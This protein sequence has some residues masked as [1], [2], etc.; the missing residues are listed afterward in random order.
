MIYVVLRRRDCTVR[1]GLKGNR[2]VL[3]HILCGRDA[4]S[5]AQAAEDPPDLFALIKLVVEVVVVRPVEKACREDV[6]SLEP[7]LDRIH[8]FLYSR[9]GLLV[10]PRLGNHTHAKMENI[11]LITRHLFN[12]LLA[13]LRFKLIVRIEKRHIGTRSSGDS[14]MSGRKQVEVALV[15]KI[16]EARVALGQLLNDSPSA[17]RRGVIHANDFNVMKRLGQEASQA[18]LDVTFNVIRGNND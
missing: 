15:S 18:S 12:E 16:V 7:S 17:I 13:S 14:N 2:E 8:C 10:T 3:D 9:D 5:K 1:L 11:H 6:F 4:W